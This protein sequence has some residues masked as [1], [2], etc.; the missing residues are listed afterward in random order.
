MTLRRSA[1]DSMPMFRKFNPRKFNPD[2]GKPT[3]KGGAF[4]QPTRIPFTKFILTAFLLHQAVSFIR[5]R[6]GPKKQPDEQ[7]EEEWE[8]G[9]H[10]AHADLIPVMMRAVLPKP[11]RKNKAQRLAEEA[12]TRDRRVPSAKQMM[13]PPKG[14]KHREPGMLEKMDKAMRQQVRAMIIAQQQMDDA[15][16]Q[17]YK[18]QMQGQIRALPAAP[19]LPALPPAASG[20]NGSAPAHDA[21]ASGSAASQQQQPA[22]AAARQQRQQGW[23]EEEMRVV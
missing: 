4:G 18:E 20:Q 19:V 2:T 5:R 17:Q 1:G 15:V 21:A 3:G 23:G 8:D 16:M 9:A 14:A 10:G 6:F 12:R 11:Q 7:E 22:D 13:A